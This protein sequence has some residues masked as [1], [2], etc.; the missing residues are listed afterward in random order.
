MKK[1]KCPLN[2]S[3]I[4]LVINLL[5]LFVFINILWLTR[6]N[7]CFSKN[8]A[9]RLA[10]SWSDKPWYTYITWHS[11]IYGTL[12]YI[13]CMNLLFTY[14]EWHS[15]IHTMH[16]TIT[17]I[18]W[19]ALLHTYKHNQRW[20]LTLARIFITGILV[21]WVLISVS[22]LWLIFLKSWCRSQYLDFD[23]KSLKNLN[24][25]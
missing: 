16:G 6:E 10:F 19:I 15:Y 7:W 1:N 3:L 2:I 5:I 9:S 17:Y 13:P 14:H 12:T 25:S 21:R 20:M 24:K 22:I 23:M 11:Y 4:D 18:P 8:I